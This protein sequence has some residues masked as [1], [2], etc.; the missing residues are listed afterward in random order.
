M[1]NERYVFALINTQLECRVIST[2]AVTLQPAAVLSKKQVVLLLKPPATAN[3]HAK[4]LKVV[5][6]TTS[7]PFEDGLCR[8]FMVIW[9]T[10]YNWVYQIIGE[11]KRYET[12]LCSHQQSSIVHNQS[13]PDTIPTYLCTNSSCW[14]H[15]LP[16]FFHTW[17]KELFIGSTPAY[18]VENRGFP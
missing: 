18:N 1:W 11:M 3:R 7:L 5:T 13:V 2:V 12:E 17:M 6:P 14:F 10:V 8:P 16:L 15:H 4:F 9:G